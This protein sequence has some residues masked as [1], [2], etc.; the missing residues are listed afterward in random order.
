MLTQT[1]DKSREVLPTKPQ[2]SCK[3]DTR[4][5]KGDDFGHALIHI[6]PLRL[7]ALHQDKEA[8]AQVSADDRDDSHQVRHLLPAGWPSSAF[9]LSNR[10]MSDSREYTYI[11]TG[12]TTIIKHDRLPSNVPLP[13]KNLAH[14]MSICILPTPSLIP[15]NKFRSALS[16]LNHRT[17]AKGQSTW[18]SVTIKTARW[19][20][21][22]NDP[23]FRRSMRTA[24]AMKRHSPVPFSSRFA[25]I[26][27]TAFRSLRTR[28][29]TSR[30]L[31]R[32]CQTST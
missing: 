30:P 32:T 7:Q 31:S 3:P 25:N 23:A 17:T 11:F 2:P 27:R 16:R 12:F 29:N 19:T 5:K 8:R 10:I 26:P 24:T 22:R 9:C 4:I 28:S 15:S 6:H 1:R 20:A 13:S 18:P 21:T 14:R